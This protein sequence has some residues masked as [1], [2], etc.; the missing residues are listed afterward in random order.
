[1]ACSDRA[2]VDEEEQRVKR[3][4]CESDFQEHSRCG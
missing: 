1:M 3:G 4:R 2:N